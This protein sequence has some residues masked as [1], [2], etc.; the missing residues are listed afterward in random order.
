MQEFLYGYSGYGRCR[1]PPSDPRCLRNWPESHCPISNGRAHF[2]HPHRPKKTK[3]A[4]VWRTPPVCTPAGLKTVLAG[5]DLV[6][7]T[8]RPDLL[9]TPDMA[10]A[11][12]HCHHICS[13]LSTRCRRGRHT[14]TAWVSSGPNAKLRVDLES[15][16]TVSGVTVVRGSREPFSY[17][18]QASSDCRRWKTSQLGRISTGTDEFTA[19]DVKAKSIRLVFDGPSKPNIA[20]LSVKSKGQ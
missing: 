9:P 4:Q 11:E 17:S 13:W 8:R 6:L 18:V 5:T 7:A 10:L 12:S 15:L 1:P 16:S 3:L 20:E 19:P 2:H 14:A